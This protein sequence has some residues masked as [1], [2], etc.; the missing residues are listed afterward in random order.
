MGAGPWNASQSTTPRFPILADGDQMAWLR[1]RRR[2]SSGTWASSGMRC[3]KGRPSP[4]TRTSLGPVCLAADAV[5]GRRQPA[6]P[7]RQRTLWQGEGGKLRL[8]ARPARGRRLTSSTPAISPPAIQH[9]D[10]DRD[11][12]SAAS[13]T[14]GSASTLPDLDAPESGDP[15]FHGGEVFSHGSSPARRAPTTPGRLLQPDLAVTIGLLRRSGSLGDCAALLTSIST[16][17]DHG[18][19]VLAGHA[20]AELVLCRT[21]CGSSSLTATA[22]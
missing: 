2:R 3:R 1:A 21:T 10:R 8:R 16:T 14:I 19:Q 20:D 5:T 7:G 17:G 9:L 12:L 6:A 11:L 18:R 4:P 22:R 15:F 13:V